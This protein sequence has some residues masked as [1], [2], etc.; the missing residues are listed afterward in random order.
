MRGKFLAF[1][2]LVMVLICFSSGANAA[3]MAP[4]NLHGN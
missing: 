4:E 2:F 1:S 3:D